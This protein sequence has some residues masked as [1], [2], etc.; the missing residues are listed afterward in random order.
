MAKREELLA[1]I[2]D[3]LRQMGGDAYYPD[4]Y[5]KLSSLYP[6]TMQDYASE[7]NWQAAIRQTIELHSSDSSVYDPK[8]VDAFGSVEGIGSGHWKLREG[9]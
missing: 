5:Q 9:I 7:E 3:A 8:N 6:A 1:Q 4:L 2:V